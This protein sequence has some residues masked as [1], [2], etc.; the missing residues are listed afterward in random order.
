MR[1][2]GAEFAKKEPKTAN[3]KTNA[4]QT[5]AGAN[6]GQ[7]GSF[8][9]KVDSRIFFCRLIH[10]GIV[11]ALR[12][13]APGCIAQSAWTRIARPRKEASHE[14]LFRPLTDPLAKT[15]GY[16]GWV[17]R[18][19]R[20]SPTKAKQPSTPGRR[21]KIAQQRSLVT[22]IETSAGPVARA[23]TIF[24]VATVALV[25]VPGRLAAAAN[26]RYSCSALPAKRAWMCEP[27]RVMPG[28]TVVTRIPLPLSSACR[29][30]DQPVMA[31]LLAT[32]GRSS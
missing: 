21:W 27:V 1:R 3:R 6:P 7:E 8:G 16:P 14:R 30:C 25:A 2:A 26:R 13:L 22:P 28:E 15:Q 23:S 31:N 12:P 5:E 9:G 19:R 29:P 18:V 4:H 24:L 10:G 20:R 11:A 17:G 32:Y